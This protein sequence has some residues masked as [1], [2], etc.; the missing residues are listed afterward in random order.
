MDDSTILVSEMLQKLSLAS[1]EERKTLL[2]EARPYLLAPDASTR[3]KKHLENGNFAVIFDCLNSADKPM[4]KT[5]CEILSRVFD[6]VDS[7]VV[8]QQYHENLA[9]ALNHPMPEVKE[10]VLKVVIKGLEKDAEDLT[11]SKQQ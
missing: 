9:R 10:V 11:T 4:V 2:N 7:K 8:I 6:F 5:V 1:E 3:F